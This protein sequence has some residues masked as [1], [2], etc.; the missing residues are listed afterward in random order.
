[1]T[2]KMSILVQYKHSFPKYV[3]NPWLVESR[4]V[5]LVDVEG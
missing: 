3:F 1:M 2:I 4:E 5:E